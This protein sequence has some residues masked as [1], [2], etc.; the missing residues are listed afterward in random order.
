[1]IFWEKLVEEKKLKEKLKVIFGDKKV[2]A[3]KEAVE[4]DKEQLASEM[5]KAIL[6]NKDFHYYKCRR[7]LI[8]YL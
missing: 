2:K 3:L 6:E 1:M 8:N 5:Q 7:H 4:K